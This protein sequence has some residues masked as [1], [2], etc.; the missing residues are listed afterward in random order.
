MGTPTKSSFTSSSSPSHTKQAS[1]HSRREGESVLLS[2]EVGTSNFG[3]AGASAILQNALQLALSNQSKLY[4]DSMVRYS[5]E[6]CHAFSHA[7]AG[8]QEKCPLS[9]N[10]FERSFHPL[11]Y[12][13]QQCVHVEHI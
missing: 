4:F 6:L 7:S 13:T 5:A 9:H 8:E 3:A 2:D 12:L 1:D 10:R 11:L